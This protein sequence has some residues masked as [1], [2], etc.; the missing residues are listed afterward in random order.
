MSEL[1]RKLLAERFKTYLGTR[2]AAAKP[3]KTANLVRGKAVRAGK[4]ARKRSAS[5]AAAN[6]ANRRSTKRPAKKAL[7]PIATKNTSRSTR[8]RAQN[9]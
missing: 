3:R 2:S 4:P 9:R 8:P 7:V 6:G 1:V 5:N